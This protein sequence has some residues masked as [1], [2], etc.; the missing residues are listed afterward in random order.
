MKRALTSNEEPANMETKRIK[1][2]VKATEKEEINGANAIN[3]KAPRRRKKRKVAL[4]LGY[5]GSAYHG[6]QK[7]PGVQT[8]EGILEEALHKAGGISDDNK[9]TMSKVFWSRAARTDRGVSAVGQCVSLKLACEIDGKLDEN[10]VE[11]VN[12]HLP[13]DIRLYGM[14]RTT[15]SFTARTDCH[16]RLYE[17]LMPLRNLGGPNE[18]VLTE[19]EISNAEAKPNHTAASNSLN[20][21]DCG[22]KEEN[23]ESNEKEDARVKRFNKI[24]AQYEGTHSFH[25][26]T[27]SSIRAGNDQAKRYM[28][29]I[30]AQKPFLIG[31]VYYISVHF[32]GQSFIL[33]QIRKMVGLALHI[34]HG[35]CPSELLPLAFS[36]DVKIPIP[37]APSLGLLLNTLY[38]DIYNERNEKFLMGPVSPDHWK[39]EMNKFKHEH[40]YPI[41]A[42][43]E[44]LDRT[45]TNWIKSSAS[46]M[47]YDRESISAQWAKYKEEN[48]LQQ[49]PSERRRARLL[50]QYPIFV[51]LEQANMTEQDVQ[52]IREQFHDAFS[53]R[54]D[55]DRNSEKTDSGPSLPKGVHQ[56]KG[57]DVTDRKSKSYPDFLT[58]APE[59][60]FLLGPPP[61]DSMTALGAADS[62]RTI[63]S[64]VEGN[65][66]SSVVIK[67]KSSKDHLA[68]L[69][70]VGTRMSCEPSDVAKEK[71]IAGIWKSL[72]SHA[73]CR[74]KD[75]KGGYVCIS[76]KDF[77]GR[78]VVS[79]CVGAALACARLNHRRFP[80]HQL[81]DIVAKT[82][83]SSIESKKHLVTFSLCGQANS[84]VLCNPVL[85][86]KIPSLH[87]FS[88][89]G[90]L[91][92]IEDG[93]GLY[94]EATEYKPSDAFLKVLD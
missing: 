74:P 55:S 88:D 22:E 86:E 13:D 62:P 44:S 83:K 81:A 12:K 25:N 37:T 79:F 15:G 77:T 21:K 71:A 49:N 38:F 66:R 56:A 35:L 23:G 3:D 19:E 90:K 8:I 43:T 32:L 20:K 29:S 63:F 26:F 42:R 73:N 52:L 10:M 72:I 65:S 45:M 70:S 46:S 5:V 30:K 85:S 93:T 57:G 36:T 87:P 68:V 94:A 11:N 64:V 92:F 14:M 76:T 59:G 61:I 31:S 18:I 33:H 28:L 39:A 2:D 1:E 84:F 48:P 7:N 91:L 16:R 80:R 51:D 75:T 69:R 34:F 50:L 24:L 4:F 53:P 40:I 89:T 17:Y 60:F 47:P 41:I 6:M 54:N 27:D 9:G 58:N 82:M 78:S 67:T